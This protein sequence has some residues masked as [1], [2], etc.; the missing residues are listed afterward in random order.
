MVR[1]T[2]WATVHR[3]AKNWTQL[4]KQPVLTREDPFSCFLWLLEVVPLSLSVASNGPSSLPHIASL[5]HSHS[6]YPGEEP[7]D[8]TGSYR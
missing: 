3:V 6:C 7:C 5:R 2:W 8:D 4:K 1:G